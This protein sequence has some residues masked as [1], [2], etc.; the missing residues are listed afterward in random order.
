M[1]LG[2][3]FRA[4]VRPP[5][6]S[7]LPLLSTACR[8]LSEQSGVTNSLLE[9]KYV[10]RA[11]IGGTS[12]DASVRTIDR[13]RTSPL[14]QRILLLSLFLFILRD[15][16]S[17]SRPDIAIPSVSDK[18][19]QS[20]K[21]LVLV[22]SPTHEHAFPFR[23]A[24]QYGP[25]VSFCT[26]CTPAL[27]SLQF[28]YVRSVKYVQLHLLHSFCIRNKFLNKVL[29][30]VFWSALPILFPLSSSSLHSRNS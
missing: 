10:F 25:F 11:I 3:L 29:F 12:R 24:R 28:E 30:T 5:P 17:L 20:D 8:P 6:P 9:R 4:S 21:K 15:R 26:F 2:E 27:P 22:S 19:A 23:A 1:F 18:L 7:S 13:S 14:Q 16:L